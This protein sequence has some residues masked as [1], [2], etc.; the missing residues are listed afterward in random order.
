[1]TRYLWS[2]N[3]P[4][5]DPVISLAI[6]LAAALVGGM[7]AHRLRQ[8][9]ILGYL[10]IGVAVGPY[11]LGVVDD[12]AL[13]EATATIGVAL[14]M[15]T[16]G[17]EISIAQLR[18]VGKGGIWGG[19]AQIMVTFALG[20]VVGITLFRW[21]VPQSILFGLII[22][23]SSTAVCLKL[24]MER[25]EL[26]SVHGRLMI[27][28]L[29]VQDIA[30]VLMMVVTPVL[31]GAAQN[32]LLALAVAA[33][34]AALFIGIAIV[35]GLWLLPWLMGRVGG[36]RSR[37]L[38][39]LTILVL[40]LGAA[41]GTQIFGL[42]MVFGAFLIGL[43]IRGTRFSYQAVAEITPLRDIFATLFFVS[44]GMLLDPKFVLAQWSL[45][46]LTVAIV[47]FIKILI[48]FSIIRLFGHTNR[49]AIMSGA[50]LFQIGE[51]GFIVAQG[52]LVAGIITQH[53]YSLILS[54]AIITML[55]T[56]L[57][58]SLVA[59]FYP[60]MA[61]A[62]A[63]KGFYTKEVAASLVSESPPPTERVVIAGYGRIGQN[64]AQGLQ[65]AGVPF[66]VIEI[67][68]KR[69]AELRHS[70]KPRI[71]G[72]ASNARVLS[73]AGLNRAKTLVVTFPDP[74]AVIN[75]VRV[76]LEINHNLNIVARVHRTREAELL[77]GMGVTELIS[78]EYE[79][80]LEFLKRTLAMSGWRK[81]DIKQTLPIVQQDRDFVEFSPDEEA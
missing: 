62:R 76:A 64:V 6:L 67:D 48:V 59:R 26:T 46:L 4:Q 53:F 57:L 37:E 73:Q 30:V 1:M 17:L 29:I 27:A 7:I 58:L 33:G 78:P 12:V 13:I 28:I 54:T 11:A 23:L 55:L 60:R 19:I 43:V 81:A 70:G 8:P 66:I 38:F 79:A 16:L 47:I 22:S 35:S 80:S 31:G 3:M 69:I 72:D 18:E 56:P 65:D 25:G 39:L 51:F 14:L 32:I 15:F 24:L 75:T 36:V 52:G 40:C 34:K 2:M 44:L 20:V 9:V 50:G 45:V 77:K 71:Y 41:V 49:I 61:P 42:S 21:P 74:L 10:A 68:P 5:T 63:I